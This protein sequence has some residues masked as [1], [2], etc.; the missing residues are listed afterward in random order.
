[1]PTPSPAPDVAWCRSASATSTSPCR[2]GLFRL[3][4]TAYPEPPEGKDPD[5]ED[6]YSMLNAA[7]DELVAVGYLDPRDRPGP[8]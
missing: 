2:A 4:F 3:L 7:L 5:G 8:T 6:P 1:M